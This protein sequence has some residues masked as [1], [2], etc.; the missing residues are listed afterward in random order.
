V[1]LFEADEDSV[2]P[3]GWT[4]L[5]ENHPLAGLKNTKLSVRPQ[6]EAKYFSVLG[7]QDKVAYPILNSEAIHV[8]QIALQNDENISIKAISKLW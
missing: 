8:A 2:S 1:K 3:T 7:S 6:R 4:Y 5:V